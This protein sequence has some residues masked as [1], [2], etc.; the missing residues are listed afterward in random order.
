MKKFFVYLIVILIGAAAVYF[1]LYKYNQKDDKKPE[2][3]KVNDVV[4][5]KEVVPNRD[6]FINEATKLQMLAENNNGNDI[7]K[8]YSPQ[9]LDP[10]TKLKGSI[11]VY[12]SGDI[13]LSN[14]WLS[15]G[16]YII[17]NSEVVSSGLV[18]ESSKQASLYCGEESAGIQSR[19]C[20][21]DLME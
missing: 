11:L 5:E 20:S 4:E 12:T 8:C 1:F 15:N 10:N 13:Y 9:D 14:L 6:D 19:L 17:D 21:T 3:K 2:D 16:Y 18:E 7:C